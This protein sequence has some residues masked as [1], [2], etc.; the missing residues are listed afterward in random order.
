MDP[1]DLGVV[2]A[3]GERKAVA[4]RRA[5][6]AAHAEQNLIDRV[7]GDLRTVVGVQKPVKMNVKR[8]SSRVPLRTV[9]IH[10][11]KGCRVLC[12]FSKNVAGYNLSH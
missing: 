11:Q 2:V 12:K 8:R 10:F 9:S 3:L 4:L 6:M 5:V 7:V 1:E